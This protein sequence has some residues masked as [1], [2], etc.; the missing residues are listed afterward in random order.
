M[1]S[2]IWGGYNRHPKNL[3][4]FLHP[5]LPLFTVGITLQL[6]I[7]IYIVLHHFIIFVVKKGLRHLMRIVVLVG[8]Y[9]GRI[10]SCL[11]N[12][13]DCKPIITMSCS[14]T[15]YWLIILIT[16]INH[17]FGAFWTNQNGGSDPIAYKLWGKKFVIRVDIYFNQG[18]VNGC[19][20]SKKYDSDSQ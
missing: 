20:G 9:R 16:P 6:Q 18:Y 3:V 5:V 13:L 4:P 7:N 2:Y 8:G 17:N 19:N 15:V 11:F 10:Y 12:P 14:T 1:L